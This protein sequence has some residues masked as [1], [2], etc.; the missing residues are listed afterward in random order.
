MR[1]AVLRATRRRLALEC[2]LRRATEQPFRCVTVIP[3]AV[4]GPPNK[5]TAL[6]ESNRS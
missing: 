4:E 2:F 3:E 5:G 1:L 6:N